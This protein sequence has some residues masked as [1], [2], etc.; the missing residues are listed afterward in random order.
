[1]ARFY[2]ALGTHKVTNIIAVK[3]IFGS[4]FEMANT[5]KKKIKKK[6]SNAFNF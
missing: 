1:M 5:I 6:S 4:D 2:R 3:V